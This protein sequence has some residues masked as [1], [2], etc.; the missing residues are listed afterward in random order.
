L[1]FPAVFNGLKISS[2]NNEIP[3]NITPLLGDRSDFTE[4]SQVFADMAMQTFSL[5]AEELIRKLRQ[6]KGFSSIAGRLTLGGRHQLGFKTI[7]EME[8]F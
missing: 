7:A 5:R 2:W 4:C 3:V 1:R 8:Q 6:L